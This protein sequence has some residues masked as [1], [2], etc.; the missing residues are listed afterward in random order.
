MARRKRA[1]INIPMLI[2][3]VLLCLT[4]FSVHLTSGIYA[5]YVSRAEGSDDSRV[6]EFNVTEETELTESIIFDVAPGDESKYKIKVNNDSE[7][8]VTYSVVIENK[9][10]NIPLVFKIGEDEGVDSFTK[11]FAMEPKET[12]E[13]DIIITWAA[14]DAEEYMGM[15]DLIDITLKAVQKD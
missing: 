10:K 7:V 9:T 13:F 11:E 6:A 4:L 12:V 14:E 8:A 5:R 15:V 1:K 3:C 2:A